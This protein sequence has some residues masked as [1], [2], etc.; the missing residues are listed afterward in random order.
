LN[1]YVGGGTVTSITDWTGLIVLISRR[2]PK[3]QGAVYIPDDPF[4]A[5]TLEQALD[6]LALQHQELACHYQG[7]ADGPP[8]QGAYLV[9]DW[10]FIRNA[11]EYG[12]KE[13]ICVA[14]G[15]PGT[16]KPHNPIGA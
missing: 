14:A 4:Q 16:W 10:F 7:Y 6:A 8:T 15:T 2:S 1:V 13:I 11:G 3:Q 5:G 9:D 12:F